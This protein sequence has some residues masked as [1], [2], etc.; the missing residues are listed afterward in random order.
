MHLLELGPSCGPGHL[1]RDEIPCLSTAHHQ[2]LGDTLLLRLT[3]PPPAI[4]SSSPTQGRP[5]Q[6]HINVITDFKQ[7]QD[8][9]AVFPIPKWI[10]L[11]TKTNLD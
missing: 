4:A 8:T 2:A 11:K 9:L 7:Y 1:A 3:S 10:L 5:P 6:N